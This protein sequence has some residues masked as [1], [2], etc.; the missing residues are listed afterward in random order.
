M[1]PRSCGDE[2]KEDS[3]GGCYSSSMITSSSA[4]VWPALKCTALICGERGD[5]SFAKRRK[6]KTCDG[7]CKMSEKGGL[8]F[9]D[10]LVNMGSV[11]AG[12]VR[13]CRGSAPRSRDQAENTVDI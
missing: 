11:A 1:R 5:G 10:T 9:H 7:A 3:G 4:T 6:R 13:F 2:G 12:P 8:S